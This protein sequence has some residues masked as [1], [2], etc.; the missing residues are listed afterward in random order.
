MNTQK[1]YEEYRKKLKEYKKEYVMMEDEFM[2]T[3][4]YVSFEDDNLKTYSEFYKEL[5]LKLGSE[6]DKAVKDLCDFLEIIEKSDDILVRKII[7]KKNEK[8]KKHKKYAWDCFKKIREYPGFF[9]QPVYVSFSSK[10]NQ[11][12]PLKEIQNDAS[13][14]ASW[15]NN[16]NV[17]KH[18]QQILCKE[19]NLEN[20]LSLLQVLYLILNIFN[21]IFIK[22][23]DEFP[24]RL[25]NESKIFDMNDNKI[26]LLYK[27]VK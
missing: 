15:W 10:L 6:I 21:D 12:Y 14:S 1:D 24:K 13:N 9:E 27:E 19:G 7:E 22:V 26:H 2:S 23:N 3:E 25:I 20:A 5:I 4:K 16:Y 11:V 8:N 17:V 18:E